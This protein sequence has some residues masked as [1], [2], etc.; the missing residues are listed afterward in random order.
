MFGKLR[1]KH[2]KKEEQQR[3]GWM[4][5]NFGSDL[6]F[7]ECTLCGMEY[8]LT[9]ELKYP[10]KCPKCGARMDT[11]YLADEVDLGNY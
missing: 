1:K 4:I 2:Q 7:A 8:Q 9:Y 10:D 3:A 11:A 5:Y 6:E